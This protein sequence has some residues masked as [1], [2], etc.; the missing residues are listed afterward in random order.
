MKNLMVLKKVPNFS[1]KS[2][3]VIPENYE[4]LKYS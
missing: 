4:Y 2:M 3:T 1:R